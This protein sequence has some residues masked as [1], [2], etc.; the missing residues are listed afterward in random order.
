M[1]WSL[2]LAPRGWPQREDAWREEVHREEVPFRVL[3]GSLSEEVDFASATMERLTIEGQETI[4]MLTCYRLTM[5]TCY[6]LRD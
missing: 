2:W 3:G 5:L 6:R 1:E 4:T